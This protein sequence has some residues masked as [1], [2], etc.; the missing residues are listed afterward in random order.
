MIPDQGGT[1]RGQFGILGLT[2]FAFALVAS[3]ALVQYA[4]VV[5]GLT[6]EVAE[7]VLPI[8]AIT[9]LLMLLGVNGVALACSGRR[10]LSRAQLACIAWGLLLASPALTQ[11]FWH[12]FVGTVSTLPRDEQFAFIDALPDRLW[13]HGPDLLA[14][15]TPDPGPE[16]G[17]AVL[18]GQPLDLPLPAHGHEIAGR[19]FLVTALLAASDLAPGAQITCSLIGDD[20]EIVAWRLDRPTRAD[21]VRKD[22]FERVGAYGVR[23][24]ASAGALVMRISADGGGRARVCNVRMLSVAALE[25][26]LRGRRPVTPERWEQLDPARRAGALPIAGAPGKL[27]LVA[28]GGVPWSEWGVCLTAWASFMTLLMGAVFGCTMLLRKPWIEHERL[29]LP[30]LK[31]VGRLIG[32]EG[33]GLWNNRWFW[34]AFAAALLWCQACY[35][36][37]HIEAVPDP[38]IALPLKAYFSDPG[39]GHMWEVL[40]SVSAV[41]VGIAV[42]FELNVL[43]SLVAGFWLFRSLYWLG[44]RTGLDMEP[45]YPCRVELQIGSYLAYFVV[46]LFLARRHLLEVAKRIAAGERQPSSEP[47]PPRAALLIVLACLTG[48]AAWCW[49]I[50]LA[51]AGFAVL[52]AYLIV[53]GVVSARLRAECGLLFGYFTPYNATLI[54]STLGGVAQFGPQ[55]VLFGFL[56]SMFLATTTFHVPGAQLE[57]IEAGRREGV[58]ART[59]AV[60]A[61]GGLGLG[62]LVGAWA[63]LSISSG[64]GGDNLRFAW[65]YDT[66]M[67]YFASFTTEVNAQQAN[68]AGAGASTTAIGCG[69]LVTAL[70]AGLRQCFAGFWLHPVGILLGS[71][72]MLENVWGSC[73]VALLVRGAAVRFGGAQAVR[74]RLLPAGLGLFIAG[75]ATYLIAI[76]HGTLLLQGSGFTRLL[77]GA[78]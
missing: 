2:A 59:L 28:T 19:P 74:E 27:S 11:G 24:P 15:R 69:A 40:F 13:P 63:F 65:A 67:W 26:T 55:V 6:S 4:H 46:I 66:K 71:S 72:N 22:G 41:Y 18:P 34:G 35:W 8:P 60:L 38:S 64:I 70:V 3:A 1:R 17:V 5:L 31:G 37:T 10:L 75:V 73:V 50:G 36:H 77:T 57:L 42:F 78:P 39:W 12:R 30:L 45:G 56:A 49:W 62:I 33:Q 48:A 14:G 52:L 20:V 16:A 7:H 68:S 58:R 54:L 51:P 29:P 47:V 43:A 23:A 44:Q 25:T 32:V 21:A 76:L 9:A 61:I 53:I